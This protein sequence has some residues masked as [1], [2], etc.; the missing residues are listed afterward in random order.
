MH[1]RSALF[2]IFWLIT[3][4]PIM[5]QQSILERLGYSPDTKL[6]IVHADD[7]GVSHSENEA[8]I[9]Y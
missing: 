6:L 4:L 1:R 2:T 8:S 3:F 7:L 5:S 9:R